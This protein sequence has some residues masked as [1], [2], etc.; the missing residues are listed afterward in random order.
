MNSFER[1]VAAI[2]GEETDKRAF[3]AT[4]SHYGSKYCGTTNQEYYQ[5]PKA[6]CKGQIA[7]YDKFA[8]DVLFGPFALSLIGKAFGSELKFYSDRPP[9]FRKPLIQSVDELL[10]TPYPDIN[11]DPDLMYLRN[12]N[13]LLADHFGITVPVAAV[14]LNPVDLPIMIFGMEK[15]LDIFLFEKVAFE[16]TMEY[17]VP[18]FVDFTNA[19]IADG[20]A[21]VIMP[22]VFANSNSV[23]RQQTIDIVNPILNSAFSMV[24]GNLVMHH[25][26]VPFLPYFDTYVDFPENVIG[27]ALDYTD[28]YLEA[29][30]IIGKDRVILFGIEG[31]SLY[32]KQK[33]QVKESCLEI[34]KTT[35][36]D[37]RHILFSCSSDVLSQ[38]PEENILAMKDAVNE[39]YN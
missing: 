15:W 17:I 22:T 1:I 28:N 10:K 24:K 27:F 36:T 35:K 3:T 23:T 38:T 14:S 8:P 21:C 37:K 2:K 20:V 32:M 26:G 7:I 9:M 33:E 6:Y 29:R 30:K 13:R 16:K 12:C 25:G 39:F 31:P 11:S 18:F 4:L 34:L 19:L 5:N